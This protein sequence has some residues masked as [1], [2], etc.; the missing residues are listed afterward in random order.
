MRNNGTALRYNRESVASDNVG[1]YVV[2]SALNAP[3]FPSNL[4][5]LSISVVPRLSLPGF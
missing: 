1:R 5:P 3:P 2:T 4:H